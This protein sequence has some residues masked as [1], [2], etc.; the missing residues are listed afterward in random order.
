MFCDVIMSLSIHHSTMNPAMTLGA[1]YRQLHWA[2]LSFYNSWLLASPS[3]LSAEYAMSTIPLITSLSDTR[4]LATLALFIVVISLTLFG[5]GGNKQKRRVILFGISLVVLSYLPASNLFFPIGFV[6]AERILYL[7]SMGFCM[8]VGYGSWHAMKHSSKVISCAM[9]I[10]LVYLMAVHSTKSLLRNRDWYSE[11]TLYYSAVRTMPHN[12]KMLHNLATK[13]STK[14]I[15][16]AQ[17][18][19]RATIEVEPNFISAYSDLGWL[20]AKQEKVEEAEKVSISK[21]I[22]IMH[23]HIA[24]WVTMMKVPTVKCCLSQIACFRF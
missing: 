4:N 7:P 21:C 6:I 16:T 5:L 14:D 19:M 23:L 22:D 17:K 12:G 18:L 13:Y 1:P 24:S 3:Q 9:K 15:S 20:L 2:Y 11:F 10:G 8:L